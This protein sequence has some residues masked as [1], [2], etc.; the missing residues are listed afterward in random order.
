MVYL[1]LGYCSLTVQGVRE[2]LE[3]DLRHSVILLEESDK[4]NLV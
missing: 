4:L 2:T 3:Y 1:G